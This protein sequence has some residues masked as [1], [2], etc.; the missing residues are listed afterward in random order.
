MADKAGTNDKN[1]K[2]TEIIA[3]QDHLLR[4]LL[5]DKWKIRLNDL[6]IQVGR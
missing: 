2:D 5:G 3:Q 4:K 6:N 1:T